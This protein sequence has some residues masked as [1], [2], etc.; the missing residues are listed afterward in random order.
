LLNVLNATPGVWPRREK[1]LIQLDMQDPGVAFNTLSNVVG[2]MVVG[3]VSRKSWVQSAVECAHHGAT[4]E[5]ADGGEQLLAEIRPDKEPI[6]GSG[7]LCGKQ[8]QA[9]QQ[10]RD[11]VLHG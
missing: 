9:E 6:I 8:S 3:G 4:L 10:E 7:W 1:K 5:R 11:T 2:S